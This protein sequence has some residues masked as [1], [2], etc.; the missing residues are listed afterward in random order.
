MRSRIGVTWRCTYFLLAKGWVTRFTRLG[1]SPSQKSLGRGD[2]SGSRS[3]AL[4]VTV[5]PAD[6]EDELLLVCCANAASAKRMIPARNTL[7]L[8]STYSRVELPPGWASLLLID[9]APRR[10]D[11]QAPRGISANCPDGIP[12]PR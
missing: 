4:C 6:F 8:I 11:L 10:P 5:P 3:L 7:I 1:S 9:C 12:I 2:A